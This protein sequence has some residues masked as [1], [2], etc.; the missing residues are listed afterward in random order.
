MTFAP[1]QQET[2]FCFSS[3]QVLHEALY[4]HPYLDVYRLRRDR[5]MFLALSSPHNAAR[6]RTEAWTRWLHSN[7]GFRNYLEHVARHVEDWARDEDAA[8]R[9]A[10]LAREVE[11]LRH[12]ADE[13]GSAP[14]SPQGENT[15]LFSTII[16]RNFVR[17]IFGPLFYV[18]ASDSDLPVTACASRGVH[19]KKETRC[20]K[21]SKHEINIVS[22]CRAQ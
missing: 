1:K 15:A 5:S 19:T 3:V 11:T 13:A 17:C 21:C 22:L 20:Q 9:A 12:E 4:S 16:L 8:Y 14:G 18:S 7:C 2:K 6:R 10:L